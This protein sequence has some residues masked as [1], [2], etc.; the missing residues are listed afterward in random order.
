MISGV[1]RSRGTSSQPSPRP[2]IPPAS[3]RHPPGIPPASNDGIL[4]LAGW[5]DGWSGQ[6]GKCSGLAHIR[7]LVR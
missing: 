2:G 1:F 5:G 6:N 3:P 4:S 7:A